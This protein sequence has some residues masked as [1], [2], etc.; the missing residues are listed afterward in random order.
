M[1]LEMRQKI[2]AGNIVPSH[3]KIDNGYHGITTK[4]VR[5]TTRAYTHELRLH[6]DMMKSVKYSKPLSIQELFYQMYPNIC[7]KFILH[8]SFWST[9]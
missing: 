6:L 5:A 7:F 2:E 9:R 8:Q 3:L 1:R 4:N